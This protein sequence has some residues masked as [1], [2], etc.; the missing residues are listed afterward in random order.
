M[1][2]VGRNRCCVMMQPQVCREI[3]GDWFPKWNYPLS[4]KKKFS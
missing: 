3:G 1:L 4:E 2:V